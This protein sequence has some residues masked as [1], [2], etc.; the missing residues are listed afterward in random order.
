ML[1]AVSAVKVKDEESEMVKRDVLV[2]G[3]DLNLKMDQRLRCKTSNFVTT[4]RKQGNTS[5][6]GPAEGTLVH[7]KV[8]RHERRRG[9]WSERER[10][11]AGG[12]GARE[13]M[14]WRVHSKYIIYMHRQ[15]IVNFA[16]I[17]Y[18]MLIKH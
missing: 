4:R 15:V 13:G 5:N 1:G 9:G 14:G 6:T 8:E 18:C 2:V 7:Q 3:I 16:I 17:C 11:S 12:D 10:R